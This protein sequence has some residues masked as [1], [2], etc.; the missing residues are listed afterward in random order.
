MPRNYI[1]MGQAFAR[2]IRD[3]GLDGWFSTGPYSGLGLLA[4]TI[5]ELDIDKAMKEYEALPELVKMARMIPLDQG[6]DEEKI[7]SQIFRDGLKL[8][9]RHQGLDNEGR[10]S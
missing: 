2:L 6:V 3:E 10:G 4:L 9:R 7:E 8:F 1:V 5:A